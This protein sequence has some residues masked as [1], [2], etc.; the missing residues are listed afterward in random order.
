MFFS[1]VQIELLNAGSEEGSIKSVV[2]NNM[3]FI[4]DRVMRVSVA[5]VTDI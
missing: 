5:L 4:V 1:C 2:D 3:Q